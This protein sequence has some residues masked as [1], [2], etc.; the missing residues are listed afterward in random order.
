MSRVIKVLVVA[1]LLLA[2]LQWYVPRWVSGQ[3]ATKISAFDHGPKPTVSLV[4]IPFWYLLQGRF[5][6][7][8]VNAQQV[9]V[10]PVELQSIQLDWQNGGLS[11]KALI[12]QHL[13]VT[14]AGKVSLTITVDEAALATFLAQQGKFQ[15]PTVHITKAGVAITGRVLLGGVYIPLDTKGN[16]VV[17]KD[18][19]TLIFHP[20]SIDGVHLPV[21]TDVQIFSVDSLKLPVPMVIQSVVLVPGAIVVKAGTP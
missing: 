19:K 2:G 8:Y 15:N 20:T 10:G 4:A 11:T 9:K 13:K 3:M 7:L 1:V 17:S 6:D 21:V 5:Q 12:A 16:L 14:R 18:K